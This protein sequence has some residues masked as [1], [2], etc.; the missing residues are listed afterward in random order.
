MFPSLNCRDSHLGQQ[1]VC[2]GAPFP[3]S[4]PSTVYST[5]LQIT[6]LPHLE[7]HSPLCHLISK[8]GIVADLT[9]SI[10]AALLYGTVQKSK[11]T[12]AF[13][14]VLDYKF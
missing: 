6:V 5:L 13:A 2:H 11:S 7:I 1:H 14:F 9:D 12:P 8:I 4:P 3:Y 10:T